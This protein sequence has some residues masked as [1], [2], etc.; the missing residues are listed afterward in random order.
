[1]DIRHYMVQLVVSSLYLI[2]LTCG[3]LMN[4]ADDNSCEHIFA[5]LDLTVD[6]D[7]LWCADFRCGFCFCQSRQDFEILAFTFLLLNLY[8][9]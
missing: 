2:G 4:T 9:I 6:L 3:S 7:Q 5:V 1:M 8:Y